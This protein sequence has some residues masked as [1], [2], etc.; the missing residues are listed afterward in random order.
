MKKKP[1]ED[2]PRG[3]SVTVLPTGLLDCPESGPSRLTLPF[4]MRGY[5]TCQQ[6]LHA[7]DAKRGCRGA[8]PATRVSPSGF[9]SSSKH[10]MHDGMLKRVAKYV[11]ISERCTPVHVCDTV[12][13]SAPQDDSAFSFSDLPLQG[14]APPATWHPP[15]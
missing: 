4:W 3:G 6:E 12:L 15:S 9:S 5:L 7:T 2:L 13:L 1:Q 10:H 8:Y 14:R 11:R